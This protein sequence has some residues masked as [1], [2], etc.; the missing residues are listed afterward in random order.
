MNKKLT[1]FRQKKQT[2]IKIIKMFNNKLQKNKKKMLA[3][4]KTMINN[5]NNQMM[6]RKI[7]L[8]YKINRIII[9]KQFKNSSSNSN[10][11][12]RK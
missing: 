7:N 6:K 10:N 5:N 3:I 9:N 12:I 8:T 4:L 2:T 11:K 1:K